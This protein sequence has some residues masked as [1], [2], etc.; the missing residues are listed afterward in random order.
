MN[1]S[2]L[3]S[4][5]VQYIL[6]GLIFL[7]LMSCGTKQRSEQPPQVTPTQTVITESQI[8]LKK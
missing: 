7:F 2:L 5:P 6:L 4:N 1:P 3:L 8:P